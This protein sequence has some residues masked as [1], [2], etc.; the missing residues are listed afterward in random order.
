MM[1]EESKIK[2]GILFFP[3]DPE[4]KAIKLRTHKLNQDYNR[5]YEDEVEKRT[6]IINQIVGE[7]GDGTFFQGPVTFHYGIHTKVGKKCFFNFNITIQD[8]AEVTIGNNCDFGPNVTIVTPIHPMVAD[9][10]REMLCSDGEKRRLCYAKPVRIGNDCW[11]GAGVTICPGV[12]IGNGC[13]IGAGSVV[14]RDIPDNCFAAGVPCKV[15]REITD[16]DSMKYKPD[17]IGDN[18]VI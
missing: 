2:E 4:L 3:G 5:L 13:V 18:S 15:V 12:T 16:R 14:T 10:R 11:L 6:E 8:D 7:M 17:I 9:E 1:N